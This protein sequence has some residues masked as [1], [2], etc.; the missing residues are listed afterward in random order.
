MPYTGNLASYLKRTICGAVSIDCYF[1]NNLTFSLFDMGTSVNLRED[2]TINNNL[3]TPS[4]TVNFESYGFYFGYSVLNKVH[5]RINP[6]GGI[7]LSH[8]KLISPSGN[9][10]G[11][12]TKPSPIVGM[13]FLYRFINIK[14]E[15]QN[16]GESLC[17]GI[18]A[19]IA[20]VPF[21][22]Y[23]KNVPFS[24][25]LWYMTIGVTLNLFGDD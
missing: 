11:I 19:K 22:V 21:A 16:S 24:G 12:G 13:N 6:F 7:V 5:W 23:K 18:N 9:K 20:Y 14:K 17:L 15:M 8:T 4:D 1:N 2:I 3:F 10:Y 25:G